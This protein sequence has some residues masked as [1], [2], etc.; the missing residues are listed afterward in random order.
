MFQY[1]SKLCAHSGW[2]HFTGTTQ[3]MC[4][5]FQ[6]WKPGWNIHVT[7]CSQ[8]LGSVSFDP[9]SNEVTEERNWGEGRFAS[10]HF[11]WIFELLSC[12]FQCW[13]LLSFC[14]LLHMTRRWRWT[15]SENCL[16]HLRWAAQTYHNKTK[17]LLNAFS[18]FSWLSQVIDY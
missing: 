4:L 16:A 17:S 2:C 7:E 1:G 6:L 13:K 10:I 3:F 18:P 9:S 8:E 15:A 11:R 12:H 5:S 14:S